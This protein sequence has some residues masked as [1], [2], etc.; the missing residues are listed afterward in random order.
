MTLKEQINN[1]VPYDE[2]E[3]RDKEQFLRFIDSFEDVLTRNNIFGHFSSSAIVVNKDK[4]KVLLVYHIIQD[5]WLFPGGHVDGESDL[6]GVAHREVMEETG[7]D[8]KL[9]DN[10]IFAILSAPVRG[11]IKRGKYVS[12]HVHFDVMYLMEADD[13]LPLVYREDESKGVKWFQINEDTS[14]MLCEFMRPIY[15]KMIKKLKEKGY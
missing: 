5:G 11:H 14:N 4:T 9:L 1:Y 12:S 7:L 6:I 13:S 15:K 3:Q 8:A 2:A 10:N